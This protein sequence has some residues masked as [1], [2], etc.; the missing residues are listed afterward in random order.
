MKVDIAGRKTEQNGEN[1]PK[2][3]LY[4][5]S[6]KSATPDMFHIE[7]VETSSAPF[8][9]QIRPHR[10]RELFQVLYVSEGPINILLGRARQSAVGPI[11][12]LLPAGTVHGFQFHNHTKGMI[13]SIALPLMNE[14]ELKIEIPQILDLSCQAET[15]QKISLLL[16]LIYLE[17]GS[18]NV[19]GKHLSMHLLA[20]LSALINQMI[21]KHSINKKADTLVVE[22]LRAIEDN[23]HERFSVSEYAD[24]LGTSVST[25]SR[26][27]KKELDL[28]ALEVINQRILQEAKR[29]LTFTQ[30]PIAIIADELGFSDPCYFTRFFARESGMAPKAFRMQRAF[31][32]TTAT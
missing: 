17:T 32:D 6:D 23:L 30:K 25:L 3:A 11:I 15:K 21:N 28:S 19:D 27:C 26:R 5:Q 16:Q 22:F 10:H 1:I 29:H 14:L 18:A 12:L 13:L 9:G 24:Q 8:S 4:G 20:A 7:T 31:G 2:Y